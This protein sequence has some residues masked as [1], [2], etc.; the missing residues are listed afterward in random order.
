MNFAWERLGDGVHRCRVPFLD[1]TVGLVQGSSATLLI[2]T[3]TTLAEA[4]A[5][6]ADVASFTG[7]SVSYIILTHNHFDHILGS[8]AFLDA[9]V[10]CAPEVATTMSAY[11][12]LL[13]SDAI[14]HG[15]NADEVDA[16]IAALRTPGHRVRQAVVDLGDRMVSISHPG[17]GHTGHDLIVIVP[18]RSRTVVF[19]GDLV[20]ESGDPVVDSNSDVAAWPITLDHV[21][22]AGGPDAVLV[23]GHGAVVGAAFVRRQQSWLRGYAAGR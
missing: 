18:D 2:D 23:P 11:T 10:Y 6:Q 15:A 22:E 21:L 8:S 19:C 4:R 5:I 14:R 7:R 17:R 12:E 13:R 20:E 16:A 1:V 9:A 3:G